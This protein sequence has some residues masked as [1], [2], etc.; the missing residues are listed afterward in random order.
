MFCFLQLLSTVLRR[1]ESQ[2]HDETLALSP[3][4]LS[5]KTVLPDSDHL[6]P[7]FENDDAHASA[8][9]SNGNQSLSDVDNSEAKHTT[10]SKKR[11]KLHVSSSGMRVGI[12][13][14]NA[15]DNWTFAKLSGGR[16]LNMCLNLNGEIPVRVECRTL[17]GAKVILSSTVRRV[18]VTL[19]CAIF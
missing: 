10:S 7:V 19:E 3:E 16:V 15:S 6:P 4:N 9:A 12:S 5:K 8:S 2:S 1:R 18:F 13:S 17:P 14:A 11:S